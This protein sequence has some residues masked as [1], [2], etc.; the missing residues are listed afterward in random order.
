M[1]ALLLQGVTKFEKKLLS[2]KDE[3]DN[4]KVVLRFAD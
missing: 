2:H 4:E 1:A 3:P